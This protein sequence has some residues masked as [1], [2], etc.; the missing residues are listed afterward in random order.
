MRSSRS[1]SDPSPFE[2]FFFSAGFELVALGVG[3][4]DDDEDDDDVDDDVDGFVDFELTGLFGS[5]LVC[6]KT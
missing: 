3:F 1:E 4:D 6:M 5:S 2:T